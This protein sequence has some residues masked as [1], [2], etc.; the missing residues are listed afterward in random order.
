MAIVR[1]HSHRARSKLIHLLGGITPQGYFS[2]NKRGEWREIPDDK[3]DDAK[4]IKGISA[5]KL[6]SDA[7]GYINWN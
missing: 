3:L 6:P 1:V 4:Q 5:S 2:F 7:L